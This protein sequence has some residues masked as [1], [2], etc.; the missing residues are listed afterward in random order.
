MRCRPNSACTSRARPSS[1][2]DRWRRPAV[3]PPVRL[4]RPLVPA[5]ERMRCRMTTRSRRGQSKSRKRERR[6]PHGRISS[7][8]W[9]YSCPYCLRCGLLES[10]SVGL[11]GADAHGV[12]QIE[13]EDFS[14]ADLSGLRGTCDGADDLVDLLGVYCHFDL[15]LGQKAHRIFG[16]TIDFRVPLLTPVPLDL[17]DGQPLHADGGQSVTDLVE[18]EGFDNGHDDFHGFDPRLSPFVSLRSAGGFTGL[19]SAKL[20]SQAVP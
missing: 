10:R 17:A 6:A 20:A 3:A 19:P 8:S 2:W 11:A 16:P 5:S 4:A 1:D 12:F 14:V 7:T 13:D 9:S 18:L 15:D